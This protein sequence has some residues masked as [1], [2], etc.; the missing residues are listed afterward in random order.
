MDDE[1]IGGLIVAVALFLVISTGLFWAQVVLYFGAASACAEIHQVE[2][3]VQR[4]LPV[5]GEEE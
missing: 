5:E 2:M 4:W 3:C 1:D